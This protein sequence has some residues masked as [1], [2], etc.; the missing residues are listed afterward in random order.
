M[1]Q[2]MGGFVDLTGH[3][4]GESL[5]SGVPISDMRPWRRSWKHLRPYFA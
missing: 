3:P 4:G 2:G 1:A 5:R